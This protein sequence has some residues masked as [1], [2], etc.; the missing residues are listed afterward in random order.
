[1]TPSRP[2]PSPLPS[3]SGGALGAGSAD[4]CHPAALRASLVKPGAGAGQRYATVALTNRSATTCAIYGYGGLQLLDAAKGPLPTQLRRV[5][6][7]AAGRLSLRPGASASSQLH[8]S[9]V[10]GTGEPVSAT[11]EPVPRFVRVIPPDEYGSLIVPWTLG[12]VCQHGAIDQ[13]PYR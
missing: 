6:P 7:P 12:P 2:A 1:V 13:Q 10:P 11:C 8:W 3:P 4:R 5:S 9:A